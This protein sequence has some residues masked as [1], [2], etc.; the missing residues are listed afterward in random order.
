MTIRRQLRRWHIWLGWIVG[1]PLLGWTTSGLVMVAKP[2]EEVRGEDLLSAPSPLPS[3][4]VP[5]PPAI[6]P[7]PVT[8]L[9]LEPRSDGPRWIVTFVGGDAR[10]AD[11]ATGRLM[12]PLTAAEAA[13]EVTARYAGKAK[14]A[15]VARIPRDAPPIDLRRP[16]D[17]W[18]VTMG[19]GARFYV[20]SGTGEIVAR[21]TRWWRFYDWM[22]ALHIM[23]FD[24]REDAHNPWLIG[25]GL[26]ALT[27]T[28]MALLMLPL[29]LRRRKR[30][31]D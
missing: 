2:I 19:D 3:G 10:R 1:L 29:T 9:K 30:N 12:P 5:V 20:D 23:D 17:A 31:D 13:R 27:T 21:R 6:G 7:R 15:A 16:I 11:P 22:W 8:S 14:L 24:T 26:I 18:R 28:V 4:L 25:F